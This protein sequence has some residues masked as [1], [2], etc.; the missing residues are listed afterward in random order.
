ML[1]GLRGSALQSRG[2]GRSFGRSPAVLCLICVKCGTDL[3]GP[4]VVFGW[5]SFG[6]GVCPNEALP[7]VQ[8]WGGM[9]L[10]SAPKCRL[11]IWKQI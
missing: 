10:C 1:E 6:G 3:C 7:P 2:L 8:M 11:H 9:G 4:S 5:F